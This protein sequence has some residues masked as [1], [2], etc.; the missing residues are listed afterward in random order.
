MNRIVRSS[1]TIG[2][3]PEAGGRNFQ[4]V[5]PDHFFGQIQIPFRSDHLPAR[6]VYEILKYPGPFPNALGR[7]SFLNL[8]TVRDGLPTVFDTGAFRSY[9]KTHS[10]RLRVHS[11]VVVKGGR[12][13]GSCVR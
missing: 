7:S 8:Q 4:T 2:L 9:G 1:R 5:F 12:N 11:R 13:W 10:G 3:N 6:Q